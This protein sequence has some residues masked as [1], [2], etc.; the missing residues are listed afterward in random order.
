MILCAGDKSSQKRDIERAEEYSLDAG[1]RYK[2]YNHG[3]I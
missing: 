3:T 2:E 1:Q